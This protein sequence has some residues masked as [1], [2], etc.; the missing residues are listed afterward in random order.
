MGRQYFVF[1]PRVPRLFGVSYSQ[2]QIR[3]APLW[4]DC[5]VSGLRAPRL[6]WLVLSDGRSGL[7]RDIPVGWGEPILPELEQVFGRILFTNDETDVSCDTILR[8][9]LELIGSAIVCNR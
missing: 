3:N 4:C 1:L 9:G 2:V 5:I 6:F 7:D 8:L